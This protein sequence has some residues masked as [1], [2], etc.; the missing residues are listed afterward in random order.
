MFSKKFTIS[1]ITF[2]MLWTLLVVYLFEYRSNTYVFWILAISMASLIVVQI[3]YS[4]SRNNFYAIYIE[5][6]MSYIALRMISFA[7]VGFT[8]MFGLDNYYEL[9]A[10][11]YLLEI[12]KWVP[13]PQVIDTVSGYPAAHI[14]GVSL[15]LITTLKIEQFML[16]FSTLIGIFTLIFIMLIGKTTYKDDKVTLFFSLG[17]SFIFLSAYMNYGRMILSIILFFIIVFLILRNHRQKI[18][19][20]ILIVLSMVTL[21]YAHPMAPIILL[22]FVIMFIF[23][24]FLFDKGLFKHIFGKVSNVNS[25]DKINISLNFGLLLAVLILA[26]FTFVS[27]W[28]QNLLLNTFNV[29]T[30]VNASQTVGTASATPLSW[31]IFL[32]GQIAI[33]LLLT[34]I[35]IK[36]RNLINNY[37]SSFFVIFGSGLAIFSFVSYVLGQDIVRFTIFFWP[38]VLLPFAYIVEKS[39]KSKILSIIIVLF[40]VI[41]ISGYYMDTYDSALQPQLGSWRMYVTEQEMVAVETIHPE[42]YVLSNHYIK[43]AVMTYSSGVNLP[44]SSFYFEDYKDPSKSSY[45]NLNYFFFEK[46][47][48]N[49][50]FIRGEGSLKVPY[51]TYLDYQ[52]TVDMERIYDNGAV[53]TYKIV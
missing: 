18:S 10:M 48:L 22:I 41:N 12:G 28:Q 52:N 23:L 40:I 21:L 7:V 14:L 31:Q 5:I 26:Y 17:L 46:D 36:Y 8:G 20:T 47:D 9:N 38:F 50:L 13:Y 25:T 27:L 44:G 35:F 32:F 42:G 15:Q 49:N 34:I 37:S 2:I 29:L 33:G 24:K 19:F 16:L 43:M 1:L 45:K 4:N 39:G 53:E 11:N 30:G 6:I 3:N 51:E